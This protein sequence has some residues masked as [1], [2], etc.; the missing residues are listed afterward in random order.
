MA[1]KFQ[2]GLYLQ[3]P[4]VGHAGRVLCR[5]FPPLAKDVSTP[6]GALA[7]KV[8]GLLEVMGFTCQERE[9]SEDRVRL[10]C[11]RS[12]VFTAPVIFVCKEGTV[13]RGDVERLI[14]EV[15]EQEWGG[16][17]LITHNRVSQAARLHAGE[18]GGK[19]RALTLDAFYR[20]LISFE[21]YVRKLIADYK[22]DE[23]ASYY[24]DLGCRGSDGS[25]YKPIDDYLDKWLN[26]LREYEDAILYPLATQQVEID[27]DDGVLVNY[28]KFGKALR[29]VRGLSD[30]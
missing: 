16:G 1:D 25:V 11:S 13:E 2:N 20:E 24:V 8:E 30:S 17:V 3:D 23:L 14:A 22:E 28:S 7:E 19:V 6:A 12:G 5:Y 27:L 26:E 9:V 4:G 15:D 10:V 21:S 29:Y 18:T